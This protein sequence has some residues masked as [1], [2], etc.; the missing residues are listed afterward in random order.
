MNLKT[1]H[2]SQK[3]YTKNTYHMVL[4]LCKTLYGAIKFFSNLYEF[5]FIAILQL[6]GLL[7]WCQMLSDEGR[8][9]CI[10]T[11]FKKKTF[12]LLPLSMRLAVRFFLF[13]KKMSLRNLSSLPGEFLSWMYVQF[14]H[15]FL[16]YWDNYVFFLFLIY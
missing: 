3:A 10:T 2:K 7:V 15:F 4:F 14:C 5:N 11:K 16:H 8:H 13:K 12:N 1:L 9:F 6:L